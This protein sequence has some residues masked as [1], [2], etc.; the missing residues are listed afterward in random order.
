MESANA[1]TSTP[2]RDRDHTVGVHG[3]SQM[4][5]MFSEMKSS[6]D[7]SPHFSSVVIKLEVSCCRC[8]S[9]SGK[10]FLNFLCKCDGVGKGGSL[11]MSGSHSALSCG[12]SKGLGKE[13]LVWF[14]WFL[15]YG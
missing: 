14:G 10:G 7:N 8:M 1:F 4:I 9:F 5:Q 11:G 13:G 15:L 6:G 2:I 3:C 12:I